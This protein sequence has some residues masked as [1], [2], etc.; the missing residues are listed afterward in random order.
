MHKTNW[1]K[2]LEPAENYKSNWDWTVAHSE[3]HFDDSIQDKEGEWFK[4]LG[5]FDTPS[6]WKEET[7]RLIKE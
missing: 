5:R 3:Y 1:N 2:T 4:V 6:I 7:D